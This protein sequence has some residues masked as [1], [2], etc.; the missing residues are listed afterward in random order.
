[1]TAKC[2]HPKFKMWVE[3]KDDDR[4][5]CEVNCTSCD[6]ELVMMY[7]EGF[8]KGGADKYY[9]CQ[10]CGKDEFSFGKTI[11]S[12]ILHECDFLPDLN[13]VICSHCKTVLHFTI[14][15]YC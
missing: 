15:W 4:G 6:I 7:W 10:E 11:Q 3:E 13:E 14:I 9:H 1:M 8:L 5:M 12:I 2:T